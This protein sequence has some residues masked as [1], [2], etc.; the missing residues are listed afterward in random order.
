MRILFFNWLL[1]TCSKVKMTSLACRLLLMV[2]VNSV[3]V[4]LKGGNYHSWIVSN[5][6]QT[7]SW[8]WVL[9]GIFQSSGRELA[10][11]WS[12]CCCWKLSLAPLPCHTHQFLPV[13]HCCTFSSSPSPAIAASEGKWWWGGAASGITPHRPVRRGQEECV[14]RT[15]QG[16]TEVSFLGPPV[17]GAGPVSEASFSILLQLRTCGERDSQWVVHLDFLL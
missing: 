4:F 10:E 2:P 3:V 5:R 11:K 14:L 8:W 6:K 9:P 1:P 12:C 13:T 16:G 15:L 17:S 7:Q